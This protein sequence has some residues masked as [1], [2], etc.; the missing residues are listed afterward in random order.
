M[1]VN[2]GNPEEFDIQIFNDGN[3]QE[4]PQ[5]KAGLE[6]RGITWERFN[7]QENWEK[8][9]AVA[10]FLLATVIVGCVQHGHPGAII[11][12][13]LILAAVSVAAYKVGKAFSNWCDS[14]PDPSHTISSSSLRTGEESPDLD[15]DDAI[16]TYSEDEVGSETSTV[17]GEEGRE[18]PFS[19]SLLDRFSDKFSR[20]WDSFTETVCEKLQ[21][22]YDALRDDLGREDFLEDTPKQSPESEVAVLMDRVEDYAPPTLLADQQV[23]GLVDEMMDQIEDGFATEAAIDALAGQTQDA[24]SDLVGQRSPTSDSVLS[25]A[26]DEDVDLTSEA[27]E[28]ASLS[29]GMEDTL[30][31]FQQ[32]GLRYVESKQEYQKAMDDI[33]SEYKE[34][35]SRIKAECDKFDEDSRKAELKEM[36]DTRKKDRDQILSRLEKKDFKRSD[37]SS[38]VEKD[39]ERSAKVREEVRNEHQEMAAGAT[40][41]KVDQPETGRKM[42]LDEVLEIRPVEQDRLMWQDIM[43]RLSKKS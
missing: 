13:D 37:Y 14:R 9:G 20:R 24:F 16:S 21:P 26:A 1:T 8:V 36:E 11:G 30:H 18:D 23:D 2:V 19:P 5:A 34:Q 4:N 39:R 25:S 7:T 15:L 33:S 28:T 43:S 42:T 35:A 6:G 29:E 41:T 31:A 17:V 27:S 10:L 12:D 40:K 38:T 22:F 3:I 32:L